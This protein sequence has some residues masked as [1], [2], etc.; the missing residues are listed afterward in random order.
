[1]SS[2]QVT[3]ERG[4]FIK[5]HPKLPGAG[6]QRGT[7]NRNTKLLKDAIL[8]GGSVGGSMLVAREIIERAKNEALDKDGRRVAGELEKCVAENGALVGYL[9]WLS[10]EHPA[11]FGPMLTRV[12]PMQVKMNTEQPVVYRSLEE[13]QHDID[14]LN[15]PLERLAPLLLERAPREGGDLDRREEDANSEPGSTQDDGA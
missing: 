10:L 12:L 5:G 11:T 4:Q 1:M 14:Q 2:P 9:A 6:V 7:H 13:I 15:I 8:L 3:N